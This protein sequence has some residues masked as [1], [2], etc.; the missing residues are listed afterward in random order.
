MLLLLL[1]PLI[2]VAAEP[3]AIQV[4]LAPSTASAS[5]PMAA[6][7][8]VRAR[9]CL[10]VL[11]LG[12]AVRDERGNNLDF[13]GA[14]HHARVCPS[15]LTIT[16][17]KR[18]FDAGR[19]SE[20]GYYEDRTG[21]H[22][23]GTQLLTITPTMQG[24]DPSP[25][26][27]KSLVFNEDFSSAIAWGDRWQGRRTSAYRYG[28]HNPDDAKLDWLSPSAVT[29]SGGSAEFTAR[30]SQHYLE[31]G[32]HAWDTGMLTTEG[33]TQGFQARTGDY[34]ETRVKLPTQRGAWPAL[35]TWKDGNSEVD[36]FEYHPDNANLL[37]LSNHVHPAGYY[38]TNARAI[39]PGRWV[40]IGVHY[41]ATCND[42]Y[43]NGAKVFSD[44]TG[45]GDDWSAYLILNLSVDAGRY[46]AAP[47]NR[48]PLAFSAAYVRVWR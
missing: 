18:V 2:S 10:T 3:D 45:V 1:F 22:S 36:T 24:I 4:S 21:Y 43:V 48:E 34:M 20:F 29:V 16:T 46:H 37:E 14:A 31:N 41:G 11:S 38:Y 30:P 19:Y 25:T 12:V 44:Y 40:T 35:W 9:R 27:G 39:A 7:L 28:S 5:V 23:L 15:G 42:W 6:T 17:G 47:R 33:T 13:P 8:T 26:A 32:R